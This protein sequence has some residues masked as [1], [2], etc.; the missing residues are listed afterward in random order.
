[1]LT[2][3]KHISHM[4]EVISADKLIR[5]YRMMS[6]RQP[7]SAAFWRQRVRVVI[8]ECREQWVEQRIAA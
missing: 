1:M 5:H 7:N 4:G 3:S 2:P 8:A 6:H